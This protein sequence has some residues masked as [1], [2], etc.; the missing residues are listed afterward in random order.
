MKILNNQQNQAWIWKPTWII[1]VNV[2][3]IDITKHGLQPS[4]ICKKLNEIL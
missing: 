2:K 4:R 3:Q 1:E